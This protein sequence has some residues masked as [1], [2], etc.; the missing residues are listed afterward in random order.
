MRRALIVEDDPDIVELVDH[1]LSRE[2]WKVEACTDGRKALDR[3]RTQ[4]HELRSDDS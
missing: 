2:G 1:H 3:I 4:N